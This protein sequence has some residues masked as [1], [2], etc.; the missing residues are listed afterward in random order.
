[1]SRV[2]QIILQLQDFFQQNANPELVRKYSRYFKDGYKGYGVDFK[3][4]QEFKASVVKANPEFTIDEC[5]KLGDQLMQLPNYEEKGAAISFLAYFKKHLD[6]RAMEHFG[7]WLENGVD[8]WAICD[9]L[10][11]ELISTY[12]LSVQEP[13]SA[14]DK[15]RFSD[16]RW[17]RR[18]VPVSLIKPMKQASDIKP[19]L[20]FIEPLMSDSVREV[21]QGVG[22]FL[23]ECWKLHPGTTEALLLKWK[24]TAARLI[25]QY[26]CEKMRKS[27]KE[28]FKK[29][30]V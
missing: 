2:N 6:S 18:A 23:R 30:K 25:F 29:E 7:K 17:S 19:H 13:F 21:H 1:M 10:C 22:W 24:N 11:S 5:L 14:L 28:R 3:H 15:W 20:D 27:D 12:L 9:S 26:A 4:S 8:N 16:S